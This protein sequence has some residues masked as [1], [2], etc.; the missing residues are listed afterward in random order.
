VGVASVALKVPHREVELPLAAW[1]PATEA[2]RGADLDPEQQDR[3]RVV[4]AFSDR[5][6]LAV[7]G[8]ACRAGAWPLVVF[9]HGYGGQRWQSTF[10][11]THLASRGFLVVAP[12]HIGNTSLDLVAAALAERRG[13]SFEIPS[14]KSLVEARRMDIRAAANHFRTGR[15]D[16]DVEVSDRGY[17]VIGHSL[18]GLTAISLSASAD[19]GATVA[20]GAAN[21]PD[22]ILEDGGAGPKLFVA[23]ADDSIVRLGHVEEFVGSLDGER[24]L[25]AIADASH[26]HFCDDAER[27]HESMRGL[28][29]ITKRMPWMGELPP[30][31][32]F[33]AARPAQELIAAL[34][35]CFV[36]AELRGDD[37]ARSWLGERARYFAPRADQAA[38]ASIP[39]A[40]KR[41]T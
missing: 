8:A 19:V 22:L 32:H 34:V 15:T 17:G 35:C 10:L 6:Q 4:P 29:Q 21:L 33:A 14:L 23:A 40:R 28:P 11:C 3:I 7:R 20:L 30:F 39:S 9:S 37:G 25:A 16:F 13:R 41:G 38:S 36:E 24:W 5:A 26:F 27:A 1:F 18:G 31:S 2:H 12:E